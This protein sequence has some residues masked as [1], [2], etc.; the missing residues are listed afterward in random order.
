MSVDL[1][2]SFGLKMEGFTDE[3]I[4]QIDAIKPDLEHLSL[5]LRN[6]MPRVNKVLDVVRMAIGVLSQ[7]QKSIDQRPWFN[8]DRKK[9]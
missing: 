9:F 6:E 1:L 2:E 8:F 5:V 7:H 3:Q 4:A